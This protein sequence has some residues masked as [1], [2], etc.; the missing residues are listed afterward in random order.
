MSLLIP[1]DQ[2][3]SARAVYE[4]EQSEARE[5]HMRE[6]TEARSAAVPVTPIYATSTGS[7]C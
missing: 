1:H 3:E 6:L 5:R 2:L 4:K 7:T